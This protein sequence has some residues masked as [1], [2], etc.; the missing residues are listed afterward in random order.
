MVHLEGKQIADWW[1]SSCC[2]DSVT[3]QRTEVIIEGSRENEGGGQTWL[4]YEF[5][6]KPGNITRRP[7]WISPYHYRLDWLMWFAAFQVITRSVS[8]DITWSTTQRYQHNPWLI[9]LV[10]KLLKGN[11]EA[12]SLLSHNPFPDT[13]P[14]YV[15]H[16]HIDHMIPLLQI[17]PSTSLHISL[18]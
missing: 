17:Y 10:A 8:H 16:S 2:R 13:P 11:K 5:K 9:H 14:R 3:K 6:C 12:I 4:E 7:C 18:H 15:D 1:Y